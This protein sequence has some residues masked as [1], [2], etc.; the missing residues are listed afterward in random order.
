MQTRVFGE[1]AVVLP[2]IGSTYGLP[3][4]RATPS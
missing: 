3:A 1:S 4:S 2:E